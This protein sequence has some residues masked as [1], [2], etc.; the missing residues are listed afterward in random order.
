MVLLD[1]ILVVVVVWLVTYATIRLLTRPDDR[2]RPASAPGQW[3][4]AHYDATDETRVVLQKVSATDG[5][6]VDEHL[7]ATIRTDDPDYDSKFL[8]AMST[9]RERQS[10]FRAEDQ[11]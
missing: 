4:V 11:D 9:A 2:K 5:A 10:L 8:A 1:A 7:V 3:R 6:L